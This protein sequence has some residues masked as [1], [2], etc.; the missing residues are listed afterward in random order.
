MSN[1]NMEMQFADPDWQPARSQQG[2]SPHEQLFSGSV[3]ITDAPDAGQQ[4]DRSGSVDT[5]SRDKAGA[6][7][8]RRQG[9]RAAS[10]DN[11]RSE[12]RRG[13]PLVALFVRVALIV[14]W[15]TTPLVTRAFHGGWLVPLLG[16]LF[17]PLTALT[18]TIVF[19][20]AGSVTGLSW[21]WVIGALLLELMN[22]GW[23]TNK[24]RGSPPRERN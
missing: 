13:G 23:E 17:L 8:K 14:V 12:H 24:R 7:G 18:Y 4:R 2:G 10:L 1:Q 9:D 20:L 21:F 22:Y 16:L 5:T 3:Q 6:T 19:A 15:V 11:Q